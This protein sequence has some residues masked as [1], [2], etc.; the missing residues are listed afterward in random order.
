MKIIEDTRQQAGKHDTKHRWWLENGDQL[1]RSKLPFGDYCLPPKVAIDTKASMLEIAQNIGGGSEEHKRFRAELVN[2][3]EYGTKLY[4]LVENTEG[5]TRLSDV[6]F[7]RNPRSEY[8][9]AAITGL[10]LC[11]A[12]DT[13]QQKYGCAF[14]F[15]RP[16][17]SAEVIKKIL[18]RGY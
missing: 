7:W 18:E 4:I 12:M 1:Y 3:Q 14:L 11:K 9:P 17:Q 15:C 8:S 16:D 2:A 10:R 13:M 6:Q 5:I